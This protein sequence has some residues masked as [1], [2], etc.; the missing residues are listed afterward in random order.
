M[1]PI[2]TLVVDDELPAR[3]RLLT[4][5]RERPDIDIVG[6]GAD[7]QEAVILIHERRPQLVLLDIQMP[8]LDGFE[9]LRALPP[10][11]APVTIF[12]T[13][14]DR[15]AV[16]AFEAH[17]LDYLLKP[18]SD[19]RFES[20][21]E[22][23][24]RS[25]RTMTAADRRLQIDSVLEE[26]SAVNRSSGHLDRIVLKSNGRVA[27]LNV[28]DIDWIGAAGIYLELHV[29]ST[30]HL[31]RSSL[32]A[33]LGRLDPTRFV[34]IHR[35]VVINTDRIKELRPRGHSDYTVVL[36]DGNAVPL[37]RAYRTQLEG[38]LRQPL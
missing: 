9:V 33:L 14:Y 32:T 23:A 26:R 31:Y 21:L 20:A 15:Y 8:G 4:L 6:T 24:V 2:R 5:L 29:G 7:G 18:Y 13:A 1:N 22:R 30:T 12:V 34:R 3:M 11:V 25:I 38:W 37:S 28:S 16:A 19:E 10:A 35:S 27:L 17:A 36:R